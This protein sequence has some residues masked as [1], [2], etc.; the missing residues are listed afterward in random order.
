LE[1]IHTLKSIADAMQRDKRTAQNWLDK[2]EAE[3]GGEVGEIINGTRMFSDE[4]KALLLKFAKPV[5]EVKQRVAVGE[6][7]HGIV[8]TSANNPYLPTIDP[9]SAI[10]PTT[11]DAEMQLPQG[12]DVSTALG[13]IDG[14]K[15]L[16][17]QNSE[18]VVNAVIHIQ[19][20]VKSA[21]TT[22]IDE[23]K[24]KL[25]LDEEQL[26]R[27]EVQQKDFK[28]W[29]AFAGHESRNVAEQQTQVTQEL[30]Q[31]YEQTVNLGKPQE[32]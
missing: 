30:Q 26:L 16:A 23:Q 12:F 6:A 5:S 9:S 25:E 14:A 28:R 10:V 7:K 22:K 1:R 27:L 2:A 19:N 29:A 11:R 18:D 24:N 21:L 4:E 3:T 31:R 15:G 20:C 17:F 32:N 13:S 8:P